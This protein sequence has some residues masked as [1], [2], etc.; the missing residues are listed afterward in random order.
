M[1]VWRLAREITKAQHAQGDSHAAP[2]QVD[3]NLLQIP[4]MQQCQLWQ[5]ISISCTSLYTL[6]L[7]HT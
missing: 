5:D 7:E 4:I 1:Q 2:G 6:Y 3:T